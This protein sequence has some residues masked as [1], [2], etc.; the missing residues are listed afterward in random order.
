[1]I[2][3]S[4]GIGW[5]TRSDYVRWACARGVKELEKY[6]GETSE[7]RS[8]YMLRQRQIARAAETAEALTNVRT[9]SKRMASGLQVIMKDTTLTGM[10]EA[11]KRITEFLAPIMELA[12]GNN[13][14]MR[15]YVK[16]F[17]G[18]SSVQSALKTLKEADKKGKITLGAVVTNSE[19]AYKRISAEG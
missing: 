11:V 7:S 9:Q 8:H 15:L 4:Q 12:G 19:K 14:L 6:L 2:A 18:I 1:M 5:K 13:Y 17:F 3:K 10:Q 16:E